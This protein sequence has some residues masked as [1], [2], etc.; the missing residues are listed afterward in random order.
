VHGLVPGS[1]ARDDADFA[2]NGCIRPVD[3]IRIEVHFD[4]V[5]MGYNNALQLF[6]DYI[7]RLVD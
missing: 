1:T 6:E 4:Q 5:W 3:E 2:L 7:F